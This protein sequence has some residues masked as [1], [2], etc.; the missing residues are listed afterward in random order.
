[1]PVKARATSHSCPTASSPAASR[2]RSMLSSMT[3]WVRVIT[4]E[5]S[6]SFDSKWL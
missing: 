1:M 4:A 5:S 2:A 6:A 3:A